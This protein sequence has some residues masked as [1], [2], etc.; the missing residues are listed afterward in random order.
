MT[1]KKLNR[2]GYLTAFLTFAIAS[3]IMFGHYHGWSGDLER[4]GILFIPVALIANLGVFV[5]ILIKGSRIGENGTFRSIYV[6][7]L[8]IPV[9]FFC[10]WFAMFLMGYYRVTVINDTSSKIT[11]IN[12]SGCDEKSINKLDP[13]ES[14]TVWIGINGD[15]SLGITYLDKNKKVNSHIVAGY[16]CSGMGRRADHHISGV[17]DR[18]W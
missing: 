9:A 4:K 17:H 15:C 5:F 14:A 8:N 1:K 2:V 13:G 11:Q 16:L 3:F 12:L 10:F 7:L 18:I 6:M